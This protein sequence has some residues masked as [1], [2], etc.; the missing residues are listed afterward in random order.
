VLSSNLVLRASPRFELLKRWVDE[1][2]LGRIYH[3]EGDYDYGR[4]SKLTQGWR[5]DLESYSV[6]LGGTI[7]L[8]DLLLWLSGD[9]PV[10]VQATGNRLVTEGTKF[11][12]DDL[13]V[14]IVDLASGATMKVAANFGCVHPH[15]HDVKVFGQDA[16]FINGLEQATLWTTAGDAPQAEQLDSPYPGV[17]KGALVGSFVD[18]ATGG[19]APLV[20][21]DEVF[22]GLA[23]CFAIDS[24]AQT[25]AA[26]TVE[27]F[28]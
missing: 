18:A 15:F 28:G 2:R 20:T 4:L 9:E 11:R 27:T 25:G 7:H 23:T 13:V 6:T 17:D 3:M 8:I 12:F 5:G 19:R 14:A 24:A 26:V 21:A 16:T 1:G 10:R 22:R